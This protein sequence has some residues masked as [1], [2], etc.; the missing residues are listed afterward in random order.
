M[1]WQG[2]RG[3]VVSQIKGQIRLMKKYED[4]PQFINYI[5]QVMTWVEKKVDFFC[6]FYWTTKYNNNLVTNPLPPEVEIFRKPNCLHESRYRIN[7]SIA[8]FVIKLGGHCIK[9]PDLNI[10]RNYT[11]LNQMEFIL[12]QLEMAYFLIFCKVQLSILCRQTWVD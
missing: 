8:S 10:C 2:K 1:W 4:P 3:L 11:F 6:E 9:Y 7:N 5:L 12:H